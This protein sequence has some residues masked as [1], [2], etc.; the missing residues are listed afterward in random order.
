MSMSFVVDPSCRQRG[1]PHRP[2]GVTLVEIIST[3][4][5]IALLM[6]LLLPTV[7]GARE[8]ANRTKCLSN[9]RQIAAAFIMYV[10][11]NGGRFPRPAQIGIASQVP[12]DWIF[13]QPGRNV[14]QGAITRY[15]GRPFNPSVLRCPSDDV[16]SHRTFTSGGAPSVYRY[17]YSVNEAICRIVVRGPTLR[18]N[19]VRNPSEKILVVDESATTL[20]DGCWAWQDGTPPGAGLN[21]LS[22]R[23][24]R[25]AERTADPRHGRG[26]VAF[27]DGHA[28]M[29]ARVETSD[30]RHYDPR[31]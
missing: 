7:A 15:I 26:A 2:R 23:H 8:A 5:V 17:S 11:E 27:A 28:G 3:I 19:Q 1:L 10:N 30:P 9:L 31:Q 18:T 25:K 16:D 24:D 20:D 6:G 29:I 4:G 13:F 12:E 21:V 14:E 22:S